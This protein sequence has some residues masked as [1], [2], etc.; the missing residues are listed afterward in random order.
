MEPSWIPYGPTCG[1][2][3]SRCRSQE[4]YKRRIIPTALRCGTSSKRCYPIGM[5]SGWLTYSF[6]VVLSPERLCVS[7]RR[8]SE[9]YMKFIV[10]GTTSWSDCCAMH[11]NSVGGSHRSRKLNEMLMKRIDHREKLAHL[12][13][14]P[15]PQ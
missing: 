9:M 15:Y 6:T 10:C 2:E 13:S 14:S 12:L 5:S 11:T 8:S 1:Q 3:K 4:S 7:A